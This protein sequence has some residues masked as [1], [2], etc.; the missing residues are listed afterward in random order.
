MK[1]LSLLLVIALVAACADEDLYVKPDGTDIQVAGVV[2]DD[3]SDSDQVFMVVEQSPEFPGGMKAYHKYLKENLKYPEEAKRMGIEGNVYVSFIVQ[4]TGELTD[5]ELV[6][7]VGAGCGDEALRV[8]MEGPNW[9]PGQQG[10]KTV[11]TRMQLRTV[12]RLNDQ[13]IASAF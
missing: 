10:G 4:E 5:F 9:T 2:S 8:L 3:N 12:F 1:K 11:K 13:R 7:S 6:R